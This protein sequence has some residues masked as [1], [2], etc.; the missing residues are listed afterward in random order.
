MQM[1]NIFFISDLHLG[2][3]KI[4]EFSP[5]RGGH[6]EVSHSEWLVNQWNK[7]VTKHDLVYVL[8]D[9]CFNKEHLK[10]LKMM[11]GKKNLV[12]GNHD[13]FPLSIYQEY[14]GKIFGIT[15]YKGFWLSHAPVHEQELRGK[16]NIHGHV[17]HK[18]ITKP[19][20][21]VYDVRYINVCVEACDEGKPVSLDEMLSFRSYFSY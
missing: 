7:V 17:H 16:M 15:K 21:D 5:N 4:L 6:D 8:G 20:S 14:F 3:K 12:L 9:V 10:Y 18:S 19:N 11:K 1:S 2:H 13:E